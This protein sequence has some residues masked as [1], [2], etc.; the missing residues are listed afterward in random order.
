[1]HLAYLKP[2][3]AVGKEGGLGGSAIVTDQLRNE[4]SRMLFM[5]RDNVDDGFRAVLNRDTQ[6]LHAVEEREDYID[7]LHTEISHYVSQVVAL[8]TN[9]ESSAAVS[10]FFTVSGNVERIADHAN[11]LA[12][13]TRRLADQ[14]IQFSQEAQEEIVAMRETALQ[15][16]AAL[17]SP[18]AGTAESLAQVARLEQRMDDMT[19][20]YRRQQLERMRKSHCN[21]EAC[22]LYSELLTDFERIGD[23][24]LNIAQELTRTGLSLA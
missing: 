18:G 6:R 2:L 3:H 5:A 16:M 14:E 4:L 12:G 19:E 15:A 1:M 7:F 9:E 17:L 8:E 13:Y 21:E 24:A 10:G 20:Q 23:H 22:I 11:N